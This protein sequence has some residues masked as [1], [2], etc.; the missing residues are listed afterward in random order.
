MSAVDF[1]LSHPFRSRSRGLLATTFLLALL[2]VAPADA[3]DSP[4]P[5]VVDEYARRYEVSSTEADN[6]LALQAKAVGASNA[7]SNRLG[8]DFAGVWFDNTDGEFVV[9]V[10]SA[11]DIAAVDKQFAEYGVDETQYRTVLVDS[12]VAELEDAQLKVDES[13]TNLFAE[14]RARSGIDTSINSVVVEVATGGAG[15]EELAGLRAQAAA[16]PARVKIVESDVKQFGDEP[17][18]CTWGEEELRACDPPF[19]GGVRIA[20]GKF[21]CTSAFAATGNTLGNKFVMTAGHC[22]ETP[23]PWSSRTANGFAEELGT[24]EGYIYGGGEADGGLIRVKDSNWWV[25]EWG[26]RGHIVFWGPPSNPAAI[27]NPSSPIY[28][29]ASSVVGEF[30]CHSG[31]TTG[32]SCGTVKQLNAK[33]TYYPNISLGHM[34]KLEGDCGDEGDSGG[35]VFSGNYAVGIWSGGQLG[36]CTVH[37]YT[38]VTEIESKYGVHVTP[39]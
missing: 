17:G 29:S 12:T 2:R 11:K 31:K 34:T 39:W 33:T 16:A 9:P 18:A 23:G 30:V 10:V 28:G 27:V 7:L 21:A 15:A 22:L 8:D 4:D 5:F 14:G 26:W 20:G 35:P 37:W 24:Q 25:K 1:V 6:R 3:A 32:S 19:H 13:I 36:S 38:E